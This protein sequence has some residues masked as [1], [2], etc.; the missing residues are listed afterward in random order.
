MFN[1]P[2][3]II[4]TLLLLQAC[5]QQDVLEQHDS[6]YAPVETG[7]YWVYEVQDERYSLSN[8]PILSTYYVKETIGELLSIGQGGKTYKLIRYKR[9]RLFDTWKADSIWTVQQWPDKLIRTEN[10]TAY[11]KLTFPVTNK[12]VWNQNEFNVMPISTYRY[13]QIGKPYGNYANTIQVS[14]TQN[15]STAI[16]LNR[17]FVVYG[18]QTGLIY[19]EAT[20]LAYCQSSP[21]CIGTGQIEFGYRQKWVLREAGKE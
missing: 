15:D 13:N 8:L 17:Q 9:S 16:S 14:S 18:Y 4:G 12:N 1:Y 3:T 20:A 6:N 11:V 19:K 2:I 5:Q 21:S 7:R 10:N